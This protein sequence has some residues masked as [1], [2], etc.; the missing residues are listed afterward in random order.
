MMA[1]ERELVRV[2]LTVGDTAEVAVPGWDQ[3]ARMPAGELMTAL[4]VQDMS[5]LPG[6]R[7][8]AVVSAGE[9]DR[10]ALEDLRPVE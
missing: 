5:E 3:Y 10:P 4:G 2:L 1:V 6:R 9:G 8:A 7:F